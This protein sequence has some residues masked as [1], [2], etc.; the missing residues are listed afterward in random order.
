MLPKV[1][2]CPTFFSAEENV[3]AIYFDVCSSETYDSL[4]GA[5]LSSGGSCSG[6]NGR[7][8]ADATAAADAAVAT[9]AVAATADTAIDPDRCPASREQEGQKQHR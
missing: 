4:L 8:C 9:A 2:C 7:C 1:C 5:L 6:S 3:G